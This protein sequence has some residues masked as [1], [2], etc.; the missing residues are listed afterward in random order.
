M[1]AAAL[2]DR[3]AAALAPY[4]GAFN[5]RVMVKTVAQRSV[6]VAPEALGLEHLSTV[7]DALAPTLCTFVGRASAESLLDQ[8]RREVA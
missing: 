3:L 2:A 1:S 8:I 7:L 5:A 6:G 4:L